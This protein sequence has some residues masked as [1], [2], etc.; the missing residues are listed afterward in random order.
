[1]QPHFGERRT[2]RLLRDHVPDEHGRPH[3]EKQFDV[4]WSAHWQTRKNAGD[5]QL[6]PTKEEI[7]VRPPEMAGTPTEEHKS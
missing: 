1:M 6:L 2:V 5:V 7:L 3:T 4:T